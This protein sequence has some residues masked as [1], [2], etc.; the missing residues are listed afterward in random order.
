MAFNTLLFISGRIVAPEL[1]C[2]SPKTSGVFL[3][4]V[5]EAVDFFLGAA[6][7]GGFNEVLEFFGCG[8]PTLRACGREDGFGGRSRACSGREE[9]NH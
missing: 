9:G 8:L 3:V 6:C 4:L 2:R 1:V 5:N 7:R